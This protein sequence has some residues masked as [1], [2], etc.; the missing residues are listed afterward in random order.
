MF[1]KWFRFLEQISKRKSKSWDFI[2]TGKSV[3]FHGWDKISFK[4]A[5]LLS[6]ALFC[7]AKV[8]CNTGWQITRRLTLNTPSVVGFRSQRRCAAKLNSLKY[9]VIRDAF[10]Y[11]IYSYS[12]Q[13]TYVGRKQANKT[14]ERKYTT[15]KLKNKQKSSLHEAESFNYS[16]ISSKDLDSI[17]RNWIIVQVCPRSEGCQCCENQTLNGPLFLLQ[18]LCGFK[19][20]LPEALPQRST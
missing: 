8:S 7:V 1:A 13:Q 2:A 4:I 18:S 3:S 17:P 15:L 16:H 9:N 5:W 19:C 11:T 10:N 12:W 6:Q 20:L 14:T